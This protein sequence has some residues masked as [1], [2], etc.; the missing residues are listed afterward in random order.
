MIQYMQKLSVLG[1]GLSI[2]LPL[3][4]ASVT[5]FPAIAQSDNFKTLTID[6]KTKSG[7]LMGST[8]GTTS[9]PAIVSNSDRQKRKCFGFGDPTP[10]HTLI[11]KQPLSSLTLRVDS[12]GADTTLL[13]SGPDGVRCADAGE[14]GGDVRMQ[15]GDWQPGTYQVWVGTVTPNTNRDYRLVVRGN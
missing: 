4:H 9:L 7:M 13:V 5:A 1:I 3:A 11:L 6:D 15:E 10:D 2:A 14:T 12:G 8:G